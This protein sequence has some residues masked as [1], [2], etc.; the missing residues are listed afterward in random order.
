MCQL[1][2][3]SSNAKIDIS[4]ALEGFHRRGGETDSHIDGWGVAFYEGDSWRLFIDDHPSASSSYAQFVRDFRAKSCNAI[5]HIRRATQGC[6][7]LSNT[8]P[9]RRELWGKEW[10]FAHNGNLSHVPQCEAPRFLP[11]GEC[12]SERAFCWLLDNIQRRFSSPPSQDALFEL[13]QDLAGELAS[14]GVFNF[15]LGCEDWL[16]AHCTTKLWY[17]VRKAPFATAHLV[18]VDLAMDLSSLNQPKDRMVVIASHPLTDNE[19]WTPFQP[20]Q[21]IVFQQ[22]QVIAEL[23]T[24]S[25]AV[26]DSEVAIDLSVQ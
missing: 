4:F 15:L 11:I 18:D 17:L 5:A 26:V 6:V 14:A 7:K 2:G 19:A 24:R 8:H 12:D 10:I 22:G 16:M 13:I 3:M 1:L 23:N 25:V 21:M 9:F 20:N